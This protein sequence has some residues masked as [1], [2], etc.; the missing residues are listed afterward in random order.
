MAKTESETLHEF[1]LHYNW[2]DGVAPLREIAADEQCSEATALMIFWR[3][4]PEDYRRYVYH[5][6]KITD[7]E[8]EVFDLIRFV[9]GNY[10]RGFY[11]KTE[12]AYDPRQD[13]A[14]VKAI[15]D[16]MLTPSRGEE[17]WDIYDKKEV[18]SWFGQYLEQKIAR[19]EDEMELFSI[20]SHLHFPKPSIW[21]LILAHP[22]CDCGIAQLCYW[23]I[24]SAEGVYYE[25]DDILREIEE[26]TE[27]GAY[28][29]LLRY[30]PKKDKRVQTP[31]AR[32]DIPNVMRLAVGGGIVRFASYDIWLLMS[33][34]SLAEGS[35]LT[36]IIATGDGINHAIFMEEE[37]NRGLSELLHN[38][39]VGQLADGRWRRTQKTEDFFATHKCGKRES[40]VDYMIRLS[41]IFATMPAKPDCVYEKLFSGKEIQ[42]AC[43]AWNRKAR[44]ILKE[45]TEKRK[46]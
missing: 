40:W 39:Y 12:I 6:K 8:I 10:L 33:I 23:R 15:P 2:D 1:V 42:A 27:A 7:G 46:R 28:P 21:R 45:M 16:Y 32:W 3:A 4:Q 38:G 11:R 5:A 13:M 18:A 14:E 34:S 26:K 20:A 44:K 19:C 35:D 17:T 43:K 9:L 31:K 30:D 36:D 24:H 37:L 41:D 22:K 25:N 29:Q